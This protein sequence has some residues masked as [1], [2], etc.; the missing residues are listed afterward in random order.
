MRLTYNCKASVKSDARKPGPPSLRKIFAI[1]LIEISQQGDCEGISLDR[2]AENNGK[3]NRALAQCFGKVAWHL[4]YVDTNTHNGEMRRT[5]L[6]PHFYQHSSDF[7][8]INIDVVRWFDC[9]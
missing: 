5:G 6:C 2:A 4:V 9:R 7:A 8:P 1:Q 3:R